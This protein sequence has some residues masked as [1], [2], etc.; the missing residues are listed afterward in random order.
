[1]MGRGKVPSPPENDEDKDMNKNSFKDFNSNSYPKN[2][3][4]K[5]FAQEKDKG[6]VDKK[7]LKKKRITKNYESLG[8]PKE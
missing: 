6:N 3:N 2:N 8:P 4:K 5:D 1:M 7:K